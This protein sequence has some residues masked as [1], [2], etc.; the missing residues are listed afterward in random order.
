MPPLQI[1]DAFT[2]FDSHFYSVLKLLLYCF[3]QLWA[4]S[5]LGRVFQDWEAEAESEMEFRLLVSA[6]SPTNHTVSQPD[7]LSQYTAVFQFS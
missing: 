5:T 7:L 6:I 4:V 3:H 1:L 2:L